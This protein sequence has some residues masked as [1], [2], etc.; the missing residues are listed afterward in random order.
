MQAVNGKR[1]SIL[2]RFL[3]VIKVAEG[4]QWNCRVIDG[5]REQRHCVFTWENTTFE[6]ERKNVHFSRYSRLTEVK[7]ILK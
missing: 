4:R 7:V 1:I 5:K 6:S 2:S 3:T